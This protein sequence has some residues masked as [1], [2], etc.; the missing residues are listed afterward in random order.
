MKT[1][2]QFEQYFRAYIEPEISS[3][4]KPAL[5]QAWNDTIDNMIKD[6]TLQERAG[7]WSHPDRFYWPSELV[8]RGRK[9]KT[10]KPYKRKTV[11]EFDILGN[12]GHGWEFVT[13]ETTFKEA[14]ARLYEYRENEPGTSFRIK[15]KRVRITEPVV[16]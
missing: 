2:K 12:Y 16:N 15:V 4:D 8:S 1:K 13:T 7:N 6:G 14:H 11:D 3:S 9:L 10:R 5:R